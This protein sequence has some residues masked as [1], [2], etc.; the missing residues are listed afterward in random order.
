MGATHDDKYH[1]EVYHGHLSLSLCPLGWHYGSPQCRSD[2][3]LLISFQENAERLEYSYF[4]KVQET[5]FIIIMD[6]KQF[7]NHWPFSPI[8]PE[9]RNLCNIKLNNLAEICLEIF[10][11]RDYL[12]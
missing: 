12:I 4:N 7:F 3:L 6:G 5:S 9:I 2:S 1:D 8:I 10:S 11:R